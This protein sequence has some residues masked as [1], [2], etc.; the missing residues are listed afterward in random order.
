MINV[1]KIQIVNG[2][3]IQTQGKVGFATALKLIYLYVIQVFAVIEVVL[4]L[5]KKHN[6]VE[7]THPKEV[8]LQMNV[9][10]MYVSKKIIGTV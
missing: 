8:G 2:V 7:K 10:K 5:I 1:L 3:V 9:M 4:V 6:R